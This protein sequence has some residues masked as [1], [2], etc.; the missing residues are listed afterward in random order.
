MPSS[1]L[2]GGHW[3]A[4]RAAD[5]VIEFLVEFT[6]GRS[7]EGSSAA[8]E[9]DGRLYTTMRPSPLSCSTS[10]TSTDAK[11]PAVRS[12]RIMVKA[13]IGLPKMRR[14]TRCVTPCTGSHWLWLICGRK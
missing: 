1:F 8:T 11:R 6:G 9:A 4:G 10:R 14:K 13:M 5:E 2:R 7:S 12:S 3:Y